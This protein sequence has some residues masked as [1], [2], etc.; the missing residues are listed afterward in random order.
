MSSR[1]RGAR[2]ALR[3]TSDVSTRAPV[4]PQPAAH[5]RAHLA[6]AD[7]GNSQGVL[8]HN[9]EANRSSDYPLQKRVRDFAASVAVEAGEPVGVKVRIAKQFLAYANPLHEQADVEFVGHAD[10]AVHL[11]RFLHGERGA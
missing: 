6:C 3:P 5:R 10:A 4:F 11:D 8:D 7:N 1:W 9:L 2:G